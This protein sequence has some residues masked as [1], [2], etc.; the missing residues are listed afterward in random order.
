MTVLLENENALIMLKKNIL[1]HKFYNKIPDELEIKKIHE[2]L[3]KFYDVC[4]KNN[5]K[6]FHIY[7]FNDISIFS[8]PN[9]SI[10]RDLILGYIR[11]KYKTFQTNLYC[12]AI[13]MSQAFIRKC[14]GLLLNVYTPTKPLKF[15]SN[16]KE[17]LEFFN[18][19]K[20]QYKEKKWNF[21]R[22]EDNAVNTVFDDNLKTNL[23]TAEEEEINNIIKTNR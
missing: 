6:F 17:A 13:I 11:S 21:Q 23:T 8:I 7:D 3:T 2:V 14:L 9:I 5:T 18:E 16:E 22:T 1:Y 4:D 20:K 19:I 15:V 12:S 10:N